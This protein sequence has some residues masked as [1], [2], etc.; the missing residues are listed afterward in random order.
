MLKKIRQNLKPIRKFFN[1]LQA[2]QE[3]RYLL[4]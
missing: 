4:R 1:F 2:Y 3:G